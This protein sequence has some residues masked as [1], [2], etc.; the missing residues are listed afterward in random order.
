MKAAGRRLPPFDRMQKDPT[1]A[2]SKTHSAFSSDSGDGHG[3]DSSHHTQ[4]G[5]GHALL[6]SSTIRRSAALSALASLATEG[7]AQSQRALVN[8]SSSDS[9]PPVTT[10]TRT[11]EQHIHS[12][13]PRENAYSSNLGIGTRD[14]PMLLHG[15]GDRRSF[16]GKFVPEDV[17]DGYFA[18][19]SG[20]RI[21]HGSSRTDRSS[22]NGEALAR[23]SFGLALS[24]DAGAFSTAPPSMSTAREVQ[25]PVAQYPA[26]TYKSRADKQMAERAALNAADSFY[27][28]PTSVSQ[29]DSFYGY[30]TGVSSGSGSQSLSGTASYGTHSS[31]HDSGNAATTSAEYSLRSNPTTTANESS[32][33]SFGMPSNASRSSDGKQQAR[34]LTFLEACQARGLTALASNDDAEVSSEDKDISAHLQSI[35]IHDGQRYYSED[36][37]NSSLRVQPTSPNRSDATDSSGSAEMTEN[38]AQS[39]A[40]PRCSTPISFSTNDIT[41]S[42]SAEFIITSGFPLGAAFTAATSPGKD[43]QLLP[44]HFRPNLARGV[45]A[46][47]L[48]SPKKEASNIRPFPA[49]RSISWDTIAQNERP[50]HGTTTPRPNL[51]L[52]TVPPPSSK[53]PSSTL[54]PTRSIYV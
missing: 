48:P 14:K 5:L 4:A 35:I 25:S 40:A 2:T 53:A 16:A 29:G 15:A 42:S 46:S 12:L 24:R 8:Y 52:P 21:E 54:S 32:S 22:S 9:S 18:Q 3:V 41:N 20:P 30:P 28:I 36:P 6:D 34:L 13:R 17:L 51:S 39:V 33:R 37:Q 1:L 45:S 10:D 50:S 23:S 47:N 49:S 38:P 19:N 26:D 27:G 31:H 43:A 7:E 44:P 11:K